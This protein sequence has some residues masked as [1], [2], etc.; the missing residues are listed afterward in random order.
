MTSQTKQLLDEVMKLTADERAQ[1]AAVILRSLDGE[2]EPDAEE[3]WAE[4]ID[5]RLEE[6]ENGTVELLDWDEA[7]KEL[8]RK[9]GRVS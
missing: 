1:I 9:L 7:R 3:K 8:D 2:A 4:V 5:R 6:S